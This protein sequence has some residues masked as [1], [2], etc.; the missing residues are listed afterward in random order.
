MLIL[1]RVCAEFHNSRGD[2]IFTITPSTRMQVQEA[3]DEIRQD[4]LFDMLI[5]ERSLEAVV[6]AAQRRTLEND[7]SA[8][9]D[10]AGRK[11]PAPD[12]D[13]TATAPVGANAPAGE[14][15]TADAA[16]AKAG[17]AKTSK[18]QKGT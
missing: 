10:A 9:A 16:P 7:P 15:G 8:G 13:M 11:A 5:A 6:S 14:A 18:A 4:P 12:P 2:V 1:P 17:T 3:P